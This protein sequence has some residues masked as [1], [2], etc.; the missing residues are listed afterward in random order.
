MSCRNI[1]NL[2]IRET[3]TNS[4]SEVNKDFPTQ[5]D[6]IFKMRKTIPIQ[7]LQ[8]ILYN[9]KRKEVKRPIGVERTER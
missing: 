9:D 1:L 6:L 4:D 5:K 2:L 8:D 7:K 3:K